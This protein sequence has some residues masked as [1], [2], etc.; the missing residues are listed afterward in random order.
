M[1]MILNILVSHSQDTG[2]HT[3]KLHKVQF[4]LTFESSSYLKK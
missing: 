3:Q 2:L 4:I 1:S